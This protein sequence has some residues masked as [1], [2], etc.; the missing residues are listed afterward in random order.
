MDGCVFVRR[1]DKLRRGNA[2]QLMVGTWL[3]EFYFLWK[4]GV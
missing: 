3:F 4:Y 2:L 1:C